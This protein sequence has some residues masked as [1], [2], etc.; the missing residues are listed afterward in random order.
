MDHRLNKAGLKLYICS[1]NFN[2]EMSSVRVEIKS[3]Q[4]PKRMKEQQLGI[5]LRLN[6]LRNNCVVEKG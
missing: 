3:Y 4:H 6:D 2:P 1:Q 5:I